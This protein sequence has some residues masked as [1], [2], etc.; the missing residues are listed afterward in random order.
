M[1]V[2]LFILIGIYIGKIIYEKN[3]LKKNRNKLKK[4]IH[5]NGI[6]GKSTVSRLI[7]AGLR[8]G[9]HRIFTK[10]TGTAPK[11]I[12]VNNKEHDIKRRG[13][14]NIREQIK[15]IKMAVNMGTD[16]LVLECMA[17]NPL[18]QKVCEE[19]ILNADVSVI[20]NVREDHLIELGDNLNKIAKSLGNMMC[21]NGIFVTADKKYFKFFKK[22]G[23][24]KNTDVYLSGEEKNEYEKIDFPENVALALQVCKLCGVDEKDALERMRN[25]K[26]DSGVLREVNFINGNNVKI[27][28]VNAMAAN[29]PMSTENILELY[30][31]K[32]IWEKEKY[33]L[34][35]NRIDRPK[36]LEQFVILAKKYEKEFEKIYISGESRNIFYKKMKGYE[37]KLEIIEDIKQFDEIENE[38]LIIAVGNICGKGKALLEKI[39]SSKNVV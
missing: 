16:Y 3:E 30:K 1:R 38:A 4:V 10:V 28:F 32:N 31:S 7:D 36:R 34:V 8:D 14:A 15:T 27:S 6:R 26:K 35:N 12:D 39:E 11:Y 18:L 20:T 29:D 13:K 9:K 37:N 5:I 24:S 21:T 33:L 23:E 22:L 2:V 17:V 19:E 25:Y